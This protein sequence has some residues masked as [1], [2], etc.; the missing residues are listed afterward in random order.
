MHFVPLQRKLNEPILF[1]TTSS[2][3]DLSRFV[4][5]ETGPLRMFLELFFE[6]AINVSL[7]KYTSLTRMFC[8]NEVCRR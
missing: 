6:I 5:H 8:V 1:H 4:E 7:N 3:G 2:G